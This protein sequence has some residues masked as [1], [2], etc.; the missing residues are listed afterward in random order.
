M[1]LISPDKLQ[2]QGRVD[3]IFGAGRGGG[4]RISYCAR[5]N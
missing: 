4:D 1:K 5:E 3:Y 2:R